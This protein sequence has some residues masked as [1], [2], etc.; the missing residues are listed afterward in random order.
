MVVLSEA[1]RCLWHPLPADPD[2]ARRGC[3]LA[4]HQVTQQDRPG[5]SGGCPDHRGRLR[6]HTSHR[7]RPG[8]P[9]ARFLHQ[10]PIPVARTA[11]RGGA[12]AADQTA[13]GAGG[14]GQEGPDLPDRGLRD[15]RAH[16]AQV[17][18]ELPAGCDIPDPGDHLGPGRPQLAEREHEGSAQPDRR[19]C[20]G[21]C[22]DRR[23]LGQGRRGRIRREALHEDN[24]VPAG[25]RPAGGI[26]LYPGHEGQAHRPGRLGAD[27]LRSVRLLRNRPLQS[28]PVHR[29]G[30]TEWH[31]PA[32]RQLSRVHRKGERG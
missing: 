29:P 26:C 22:G 11:A 3:D 13:E 27:V 14:K 7:G 12:P 6:V 1:R 19:L 31:L 20:C 8:V 25:G 9:A 15:H 5:D 23:G 24:P 2:H 30:R 32:D 17:V 16:L 28:R 4:G 10:H 21:D 18:S